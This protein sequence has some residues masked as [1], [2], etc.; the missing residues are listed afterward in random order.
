M[1]NCKNFNKNQ[2]EE[3]EVV[4]KAKIAE[5]ESPAINF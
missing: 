2:F 1:G 3:V 4:M 5:S